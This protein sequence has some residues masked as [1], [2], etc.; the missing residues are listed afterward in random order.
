[1]VGITLPTLYLVKADWHPHAAPTLAALALCSTS[2]A[3]PVPPQK[4]PARFSLAH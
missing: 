3:T 2:L 1:M 4:S